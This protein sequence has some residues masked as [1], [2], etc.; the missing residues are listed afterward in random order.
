V[1]KFLTK[2]HQP[3]RLNPLFSSF[4]QCGVIL[5]YHS[6]RPAQVGNHHIGQGEGATSVPQ[7]HYIRNSEYS[8]EH[9]SF[10]LAWVLVKHNLFDL[11]YSMEVEAIESA[12]QVFGVDG[13]GGEKNDHT[14]LISLKGCLF[15][16]SLLQV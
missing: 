5:V 3:L 8:R 7:K 6:V 15:L 9:G 13:H 12:F 10:T 11:P 1:F 4:C 2:A 14:P 16:S